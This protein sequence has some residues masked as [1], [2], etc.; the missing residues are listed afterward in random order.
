MSGE[1]ERRWDDAV[2][3]AWRE[4]R[5]RLA[6]P[7]PGWGR[8]S[9]SSSRCRTRSRVGPRPTARWL[10][11]TVV[12]VEAVSNVYLAAEYELDEAAGVPSV[13]RVPATRGPQ[14]WAEVEQLLGRPRAARGGPRGRDDRAGAARGVRRAA[15]VYLDADGLEPEGAV[16]HL[17]R[18]RGPASP[19]RTTPSNRVGRRG[20]GIIDLA[21]AGL[22]RAPEWDDDGDLP[23]PTE[24]GLVWVTVPD[25]PRML[26]PASWSTT[27]STRPRSSRST[28]ST[29]RVRLDLLPHDQRISVTASSGSRGRAGRRADR[30]RAAHDAGGRVG[31]R[32][33][34]SAWSTAHRAR[35]ASRRAAG[36]RRRT[37]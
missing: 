16:R 35:R 21:V 26:C 29:A 34:P 11:A 3:T 15:P 10:A 2:E 27:S 32:P 30:D 25:A 28:C 33:R 31:T 37:P 23:L 5:Q 14:D 24:R 19:T 9:R 20:A 12:R 13:A 7:S 8:T 4:F 36:S 6:D 18:S 22:R 1:L 17:R